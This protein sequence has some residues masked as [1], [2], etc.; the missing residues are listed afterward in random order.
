MR[1]H[2]TQRRDRQ[3]PR[4]QAQEAERSGTVVIE[5]KGVSFQYGDRLVIGNLTTTILRGDKV[6]IIASEQDNLDPPRAGELP[7]RGGRSG[8][9]PACGSAYFDQLTTR[10]RQDCPAKHQRL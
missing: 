1:E 3:G 9:T 5:A 6:K 4:I 8:T 10:R 2:L 7:A